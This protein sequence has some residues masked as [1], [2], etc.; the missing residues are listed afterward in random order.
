MHELHNDLDRLL[1]RKYRKRAERDTAMLPLLP[2]YAALTDGEFRLVSASAVDAHDAGLAIAL[3]TGIRDA[4]VEL[5]TAVAAED[6]LAAGLATSRLGDTLR[7]RLW[8]GL[9]PVLGESVAEDLDRHVDLFDGLL[10][11]AVA[12]RIPDAFRGRKYVDV[13][14]GIRMAV[15]VYL[16]RSLAADDSSARRLVPLLRL[17]TGTLPLGETTSPPCRWILLAA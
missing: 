1:G 4:A 3:A 17:I 14:Y 15:R 8:T 7:D 12:E 5:V 9:Q 13:L 10:E 2:L 6:A 16:G 11:E